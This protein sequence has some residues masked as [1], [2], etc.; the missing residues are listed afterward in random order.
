[1]TVFL[2]FANL[3]A[4]EASIKNKLFRCPKLG[5]EIT[6]LYCLQESG[7]LP[8]SRIMRCWSHF[9]DVE[10]V[11]KERLTPEILERFLSSQ[12]KDKVTSLLELIEAAKKR[13]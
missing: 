11:L 10:S 9:F 7:D 6:F 3:S 8:C 13:K 2:F 1:M 12:P 4:M 5:D